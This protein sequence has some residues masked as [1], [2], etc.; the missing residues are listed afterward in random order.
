MEITERF[1]VAYA[2]PDAVNPYSQLKAR[3]IQLLWGGP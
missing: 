3:A 1:K 2:I